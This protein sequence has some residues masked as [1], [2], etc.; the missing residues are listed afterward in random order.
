MWT[1][2]LLA[3][4]WDL[5]RWVIALVLEHE[6]NTGQTMT[7]AQ[8]DTAIRGHLHVPDRS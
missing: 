2:A 1:E 3:Q 5:L 8:L 6:R 4:D 7:P